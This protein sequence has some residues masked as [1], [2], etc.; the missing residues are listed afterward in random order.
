MARIIYWLRKRLKGY[1]RYCR[2]FCG[3]CPGYEHCRRF[4]FD[5]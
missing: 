4:G 2:D 3:T 1:D 5:R